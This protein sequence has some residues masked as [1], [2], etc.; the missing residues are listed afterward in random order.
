MPHAASETQAQRGKEMYPK[1]KAKLK[2][3][4]MS[5]DTVQRFSI[6]FS[7]EVYSQQIGKHSFSRS[8]HSAEK[9][10]RLLGAKKGAPFSLSVPL[11]TLK[12]IFPFLGDGGNHLIN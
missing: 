1:S 8:H 6:P 10:R 4:P 11:Q 7:G 5:P 12:D 3:R 9:G 2:L